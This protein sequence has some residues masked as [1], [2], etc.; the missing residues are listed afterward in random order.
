MIFNLVKIIELIL[1]KC[2]FFA[3]SN[4]YCHNELL[5]VVREFVKRN[6]VLLSV[7]VKCRQFNCTLDS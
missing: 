3:K 7:C 2:F 1:A 6:D 5:L 4:C